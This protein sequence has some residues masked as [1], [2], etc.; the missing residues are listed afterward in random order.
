[1]DPS[2]YD[3]AEYDE[4]KIN[5]VFIFLLTPTIIA[6]ITKESFANVMRYD[7]IEFGLFDQQYD[8]QNKSIV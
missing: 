2:K 3:D 1:M 7:I 8:Q 4:K 5:V 6:H